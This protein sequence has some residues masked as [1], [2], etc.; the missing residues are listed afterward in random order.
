MNQGQILPVFL[1]LILVTAA[2]VASDVP[3]CDRAQGVAYFDIRINSHRLEQATLEDIFR[4][5]GRAP[6]IYSKVEECCVQRAV[7]YISPDRKLAVHFG[8]W[9]KSKVTSFEISNDPREIAS[10]K[11]CVVSDRLAKPINNSLGLALGMRRSEIVQVLGSTYRQSSPRDDEIGY[12]FKCRR[13]DLD[14][15]GG[16]EWTRAT[17]IKVRFSDDRV[18]YI[19]ITQDTQG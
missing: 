12:N 10:Y 14:T 17:Y 3:T 8:G 5:Y 11:N 2:C 18:T 16:E 9:E 13:L 1:A 7:C 15:S 6:E 19:Q 4:E